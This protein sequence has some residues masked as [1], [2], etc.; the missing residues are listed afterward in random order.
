VTSDLLARLNARLA[1]L[2][3]RADSGPILDDQA[4]DE[5]RQLL[6]LHPLDE[7]GGGQASLE[8]IRVIAVVHWTRYCLR[9]ADADDDLAAAA[10]LFSRLYRHDPAAV[11]EPLLPLI[12][13]GDARD[14][15]PPLTWDRLAAPYLRRYQRTSD[16][17][18]LRTAVKLLAA[19][20]DAS[21]P[22]SRQRL[23]AFYQLVAALS[24]LHSDT[25]EA[26]VLE[27]LITIA[28]AEVG[29]SAAGAHWGM[30]L[31]ALSNVLLIYAAR[32][33]DPQVLNEA[34]TAAR[35]AVA[36]VPAGEALRALFLGNL[37]TALLERSRRSGH[38]SDLDEAVS[39][40][41]EAVAFTPP[42]EG[43]DLPVR[44]ANLSAALLEAF[45]ETGDQQA[46]GEAVAA[47]RAAAE[48]APAGHPHR[49]VLHGN[50]AAALMKLHESTGNRSALDEALALLHD[51]AGDLRQAG[52]DRQSALTMLSSAL[53]MN[54]AGTGDTSA[55]LE[56]TEAARAAVKLV[57]AGH[58][59]RPVLLGN[60]GA[61]LR[62]L[63]D[64]TGDAAVL[65]Q[66]VGLLREAV[67]M[68][69]AGHP[70]LPWHLSNLGNALRTRSVLTSDQ[71]DLRAAVGAGRA[72]LRLLPAG[73]PDRPRFLANLGVILW[74]LFGRTGDTTAL[75]EAAGVLAE[76][77]ST[78]PAGHPDLT[79]RLVN[80]ASVALARFDHT[81]DDR[82]RQQAASAL[83]AAYTSGTGP[84]QARIQAAWAFADT[85]VRN[86]D[87]WEAVAAFQ[88]AVD[89]LP[90][91][92]PLSLGRGDRERRLGRLL[93]LGSE[94]AAAALSAG[95][96]ELAVELLEHARGVLLGEALAMRHSSID[97]LARQDTALADAFQ[98][99]LHMQQALS[100]DDD[101][102]AAERRRRL[103]AEFEE[104]LGRIRTLPGFEEFLRR[105]RVTDLRPAA[106]AGPIVMVN[107]A[108]HRSDA[109]I[110]T[111]DPQAPVRAVSLPLI[112]AAT[113]TEQVND[114]L[115]TLSAMERADSAEQRNDAQR[116]VERTLAWTWDA[117]VGPALDALGITGP[118]GSDQPW[119]AVWWCPIGLT[120]YLP[121]HAA[122]HPGAG[123]GTDVPSALDRVV[124]S[125]TPTVQ[126]LAF[127]RRRAAAPRPEPGAGLS[128]ALVVGVS[129]L[130]GAFRLPHVLTEAEVL[131]RILPGT[132]VLL[133]ERAN[134][135]TV[136]AELPR[137]SVLHFACHAATDWQDASASYLLLYDGALSVQD[138]LSA[139]S[140]DRAELVVLSACST[141]RVKA[142]SADEAIHLSSAF[143]AAGARHVVGTLWAADDRIAAET[144]ERLYTVLTGQGTCPP[145]TERTALAL[146]TATRA[147]RDKYP[148]WPGLWAPFVHNGR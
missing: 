22:G 20:H 81:G 147:M 46:L 61:M 78:T 80:F 97:D 129:D 94:A 58:P 9:E 84:A 15:L 74:R 146:H 83:H 73:H 123:D 31:S 130:P 41:R 95:H 18:A 62:T 53:R 39:A 34:V 35:A 67:S 38:R 75:D 142:D 88:A 8:A 55:L 145:S 37:G 98:R 111:A 28:R 107:V 70:R 1:A 121:L 85:A 6:A 91:V 54:Y 79:E 44:L 110:L 60:L 96:A 106:E 29:E 5:A 48:T 133:A 4:A 100:Y 113:L 33:A 102:A 71:E 19:A 115:G 109:L 42:G 82:D 118:P 13:T 64:R 143:L 52:S 116:A 47:A 49:A 7:D 148:R 137:H 112:T 3:D 138:L 136:L 105:P 93:G 117:I 24:A 2:A 101:P 128:D 59:D 16:L 120:A 66:A 14:D 76:A 40:L 45:E 144:A 43:D 21:E 23:R 27:V 134:R 72:A 63:F 139:G 127:A 124:S 141:T 90:Q 119:P 108:S 114:F 103:A 87:F 57:P 126:A 68:T 30:A 131:P 26:A 125:Y 32:T 25:G 11:P 65:D 132:T 51:A 56:A 92:A 99:L 36:S 77:V 86:G 135:Q 10:G 89:L 140:L 104:L 50:L 17:P 122:G 69:P 12:D